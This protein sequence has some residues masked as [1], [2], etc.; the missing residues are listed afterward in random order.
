MSQVDYK[1]DLPPVPSPRV[2]PD[3]GVMDIPSESM[4]QSGAFGES[5]FDIPELL[6]VQQG[7][8]GFI[9]GQ[10]SAT[11]SIANPNNGATTAEYQTALASIYATL[12]PKYGDI[13]TFITSE[14]AFDSRFIVF[15]EGDGAPSNSTISFTSSS[16]TWYAYNFSAVSLSGITDAIDQALGQFDRSGTVARDDDLDEEVAGDTGAEFQISISN[17]YSTDPLTNALEIGGA[18]NVVVDS[19][20]VEP[21]EGLTHSVPQKSN[22][23]L[24]VPLDGSVRFLHIYVQYEIDFSGA[25]GSRVANNVTNGDIKF[26]EANSSDFL[27]GGFF[28]GSQTVYTHRTYI[29]NVQVVR[30]DRRRFAKIVQFRS[31]QINGIQNFNTKQG[32]TTTDSEG[33]DVADKTKSG[34]REVILCVNGQAYSTF[35]ITSALFEI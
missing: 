13:I 32:G 27:E 16:G 33:N 5:S 31:G 9:F 3:L 26:Y 22:N 21:M 34:L 25:Q 17:L 35:I 11:I 8:N 19:G 1:I 20:T 6:P 7:Q 15:P 14:S 29:G 23:S 28:N 24:T 2:S 12:K 4:P 30:R 18:P 10:I